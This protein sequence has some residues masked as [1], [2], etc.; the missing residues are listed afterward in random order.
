M[1]ALALV[2]IGGQW[3]SPGATRRAVATHK[4]S[5]LSKVR[6][7]VHSAH[8][9]TTDYGR[10]KCNFCCVPQK[11]NE[12]LHVLFKSSIVFRYRMHT[13]TF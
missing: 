2:C 12:F 7:R 6:E 10:M 5:W 8:L 3:N 9:H 4:V 1:N 11:R 13:K